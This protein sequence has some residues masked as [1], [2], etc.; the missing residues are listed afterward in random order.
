MAELDRVTRR[1]EGVAG[2]LRRGEGEERRAEGLTWVGGSVG[3]VGLV[4]L[5]GLVG[6]LGL[7][8]LVG[9]AGG[10]EVGLLTGV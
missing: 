6:V 7:L 8:R 9:W 1:V 4:R 5:V 2:V 10:V 3:V